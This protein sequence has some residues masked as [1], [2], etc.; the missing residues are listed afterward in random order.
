[1]ATMM[2]GEEPMRSSMRA[3][4]EA[5][6]QVKECREGLGAASRIL[7]REPG[8]AVFQQ[9][10]AAEDTEAHGE[11]MIVVSLDLDASLERPRVDFEGIL[12]LDDLLAELLQLGRHAGDAVGLLLARV[13]NAGDLC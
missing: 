9:V 13:G 10:V 7:D 11:T 6:Q 12:R 8:L 5:G 1:M 4:P 2:K 3:R